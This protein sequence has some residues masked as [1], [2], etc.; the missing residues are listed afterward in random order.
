MAKFSFENPEVLKFE[1]WNGILGWKTGGKTENKASR[2]SAAIQGS[3]G[4]WVQIFSPACAQSPGTDG[5]LLAA[6]R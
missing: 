3:S 1:A 5:D 2:A 4:S 6:P